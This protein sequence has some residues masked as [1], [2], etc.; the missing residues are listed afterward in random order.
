M[1][2]AIALAIERDGTKR[3][4]HVIEEQHDIGP[5]M[6]DDKAVARSAAKV[7]LCL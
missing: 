7:T 4:E 5:L 3:N 6:A 1:I 2:P